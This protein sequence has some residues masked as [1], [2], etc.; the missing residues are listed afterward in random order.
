MQLHR[1]LGNTRPMRI[2]VKPGQLGL[3]PTQLIACW[4][5][6]DELGFESIWTFDH[7]SGDRLCYEPLSLLAA[8]ATVTSH[9]RIGCLVLANGLRSPFSLA[10]QIATIDALSEGRLE[11]GFGAGDLFAKADFD[12]AGIPFPQRDTRVGA[13]RDTLE[14][15]QTSL[16]AATSKLSAVPNQSHVPLLVGGRS[17][18]IRQVATDLSIGWNFPGSID[19]APVFGALSTTMPD[20]QVQVFVE[21]NMDVRPVIDAYRDAGATRLVL[22][23]HEPAI[24]DLERVARE[25]LND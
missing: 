17:A 24:S 23:L 14:I 3:S 11:V 5:A 19:E 21:A 18:D 16:A 2:G 9:S 10:A 7:L 25:A 13:L 4:R 1:P 20:A 15:V 22:V 6:A 12:A 8:M